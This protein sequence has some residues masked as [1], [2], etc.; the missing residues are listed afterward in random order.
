[1]PCAGARYCNG[2]RKISGWTVDAIQSGESAN[3]G[4]PDEETTTNRGLTAAGGMPSYPPRR[5]PNRRLT[6]R[7]WLCRK[8][9]RSQEHCLRH[10]HVNC[11]S[12]S[13]KDVGDLGPSIAR[14]GAGLQYMP[15]M[16]ARGAQRER[17]LDHLFPPCVRNCT[18]DACLKLIRKPPLVQFQQRCVGMN[19]QPGVGGFVARCRRAPCGQRRWHHRD[20]W[21]S[22]RAR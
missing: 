11:G 16:Q 9:L 1:M 20:R 5:R 21:Q 17:S 6:V 12:S 4:T 7:F 3:R 2:E 15:A 14:T 8:A 19:H 13:H 18:T 10:D 22:G